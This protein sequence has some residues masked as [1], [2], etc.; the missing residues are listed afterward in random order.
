[1]V[2]RERVER[3]VTVKLLALLLLTIIVA[4]CGVR[5]GDH[6]VS[7]KC[8]WSEEA[9]RSLNLENYADRKHLRYDAITAEDIA[10]RWADKYAGLGSNQFKGFPDYGRRR[11]ECMEAM[12][13]GIANSHGL[14][15]A[16]VSEYRLKRD[17]VSD[18]SVILG[19]G[20]LYGLVAYY[21]VTLIRR[22]FWSGERI[23]F[24]IA[25][26]AMSVV[27][28][29]IA[30]IVGDLWS[31]LIEN[32]QMNSGHLSYRVARVPW[33]QH[34]V[35]MFFYCLGVFWL[36]AVVRSCVRIRE[37]SSPAL[38]VLSLRPSR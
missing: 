11:D 35:V 17:I 12:F 22:R 33:R 23:G 7:S 1:M 26:I 25:T 3:F 8:E 6:P 34:W 16:I 19:F 27:A 14:D 28:T 10:I 37:E 20:V 18:S 15:E 38:Q 21:L 29:M 4:G 13:Q 2:F 30:V 5:P 9:G 31:L 36:A 24:L 32:L